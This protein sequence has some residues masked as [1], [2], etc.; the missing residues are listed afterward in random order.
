MTYEEIM[1][2]WPE[3][4]VNVIRPLAMI[5]EEKY[6]RPIKQLGVVLMRDVQWW[7]NKATDLY[8]IIID[9]LVMEIG[10]EEFKMSGH[11]LH[12]LKHAWSLVSEAPLAINHLPPGLILDTED[13]TEIMYTW[14]SM[15]ILYAPM[16][17]VASSRARELFSVENYKKYDELFEGMHFAT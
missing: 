2:N 13:K 17:Y 10:Y 8:K 9:S 5:Q 16:V 14:K 4:M 1:S 15:V 6:K 3:H 11:Q 7:H 12:L